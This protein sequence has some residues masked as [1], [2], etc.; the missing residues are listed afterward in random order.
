[1]VTFYFIGGVENESST[2]LDSNKACC[3]TDESRSA[4]ICWGSC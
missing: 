1:M 3:Q 4:V 2:P